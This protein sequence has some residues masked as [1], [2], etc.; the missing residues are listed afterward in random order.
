MLREIERTP[1]KEYQVVL[2][3]KYATSSLHFK[4]FLRWAVLNNKTPVITKIPEY[5]P[6][7]V[8]IGLSYMKFEKAMRMLPQFYTGI[9]T[10]RMMDRL[11]MVLEEMSWLEAPA[12]EMIVT[13]SFK[14]S[15][16]TKE[17][18]KE[19]FPDLEEIV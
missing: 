18:I 7:M 17:L 8:D 14:S 4:T 1:S 15:V 3:R 19:V 5:K 11:L 2:L 13:N 12:Y 6:N 10:K 9:L 16:V